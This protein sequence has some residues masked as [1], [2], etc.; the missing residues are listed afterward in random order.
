MSCYP[1]FTFE[2]LD[3]LFSLGGAFLTLANQLQNST[4][5]WHIHK[6]STPAQMMSFNTFNLAFYSCCLDSSTSNAPHYDGIWYG[7]ILLDK[8]KM[9]LLYSTSYI[10]IYFLCLM[11]EFLLILSFGEQIRSLQNLYDT[12]T[13]GIVHTYDPPS[14]HSPASP[15]QVYFIINVITDWIIWREL[16]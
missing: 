3:V 7:Y 2:W 11:N 13:D 12:E 8:L 15:G 5:T 16:Q 9:C 14:F 1:G 10:W 6:T 4:A